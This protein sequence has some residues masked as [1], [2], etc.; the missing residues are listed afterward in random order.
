MASRASLFTGLMPTKNRIY[1][2]LS[3]NQL[4]PEVVTLNKYFSQ[5]DYNV[6]GIGKL[7]HF[8]EDNIKQFGESWFE[9]EPGSGEK[10]RGYL[11]PDAISQIINETGP[12]WESAD[13]RDNEYRDGFYADRAVQKLSELKQT[14]QPFFLAVGFK[15]PLSVLCTKK[16]LGPV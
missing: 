13:V 11:T 5:H 3:V 12:A 15:S 10:G 2:N 9:D 4:M 1:S 7:Y 8:K 14:S 16:V 6:S